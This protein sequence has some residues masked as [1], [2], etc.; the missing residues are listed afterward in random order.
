MGCTRTGEL[1]VWELELGRL[2]SAEVGEG[3]LEKEL[4]EETTAGI[5]S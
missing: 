3:E 4:E 5:C 1:S 2:I